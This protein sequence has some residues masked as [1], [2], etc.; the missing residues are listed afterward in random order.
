MVGMRAVLSRL[1]PA[2]VRDRPTG[3]DPF[4]TL[5]LQ[6]RLARL[7]TELTGLDVGGTRPFGSWHH[8]RAA[9]EAYERTLDDACELAG[10]PVE[11]GRGP[12][13]RL[14]AEAMLHNAGWRW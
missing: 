7:E 8:I 10:L 12:V 4:L 5:E 13:H 6:T 2:W 3:P 9:R 14:L 11:P 1:L